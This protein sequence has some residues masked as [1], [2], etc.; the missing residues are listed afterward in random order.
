M[1]EANNRGTYEERKKAAIKRKKE[2]QKILE[3]ERQEKL[4]N[5]TPEQRE[6]YETTQKK[7]TS[8]L[9]SSMYNQE[10]LNNTNVG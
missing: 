1:G 9:G 8:I 7:L 10:L 5:M 3:K 4:K 6:K 2:M